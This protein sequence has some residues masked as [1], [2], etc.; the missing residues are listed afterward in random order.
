M[1]PKHKVRQTWPIFDIGTH[2]QIPLSRRKQNHYLFFSRSVFFFFFFASQFV[3]YHLVTT[4]WPH[5][6]KNTQHWRN[7]NKIISYKTKHHLSEHTLSTEV[8]HRG[9][10]LSRRLL[11]VYTE[12]SDSVS[13]HSPLIPFLF[14]ELLNL[15]GHR[16]MEKGK[17]L[18]IFLK[19]LGASKLEMKMCLVLMHTQGLWSPKLISKN[20]SIA[21]CFFGKLSY[22]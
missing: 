5:V 8:K 13:C 16:M 12:I 19:I 1:P 15:A 4:R 18:S 22:Y 2:S 10:P 7:N 9:K 21:T 6:K 3:V 20:N 17:V 14:S 11:G